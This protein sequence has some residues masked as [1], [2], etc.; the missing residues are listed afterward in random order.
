MKE[1]KQTFIIAEA[2]VNHNGSLEIALKLVLEA[3]RAGADCIKFQTFK[4]RKLVTRAAAKAEYQKK[5]TSADESQYEMIRKLE[6]TEADHRALM[7]SCRECG[8]EF[9]SSPFDE[10][11]ADLLDKLGVARFKVPS[12]EVTNRS[13][14]KHLAKKQKPLILSTGMCTLA[15]VE[16]AVNEI[17]ATGNHRIT[18]LH[19]VTE[20]P[21]PFDQIN[22]RAMETMVKAF[23]LPVGYSDHTPGIEVPVA[24]VALGAK[25]IE[26]HFTLDKN[27]EG[28]D[29]RAS[30]E[31]H[32][33]EQMIRAIRNVEAALG[34]G[35]KAPAACEIANRTVARKSLVAGRS[36]C[37]GTRLAA[38]DIAVK[39][40]GHGIQP[41]DIDKVIG[42]EIK[43][44]LEMDEVI[45]WG[46]FK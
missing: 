40:P 31:P 14:L 18:L 42:I 5:A 21:A 32:E 10:E 44:D 2:G 8:I 36:I 38:A 6:L 22:L 35:I 13:L 45:T 12:G 41:Q 24:A 30:L 17:R 16:D 33:L 15:D 7:A 26:K 1:L 19:C 25:V 27:M 9:L 28:P 11:S 4:T 3:K 46:D 43:R 34:S 20:Y 37:K 23:R 39:R 29:H